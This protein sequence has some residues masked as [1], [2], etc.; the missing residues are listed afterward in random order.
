[1]SFVAAWL[2]VIVSVG[3][4]LIITSIAELRF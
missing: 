2:L 4:L 1:V 3:S